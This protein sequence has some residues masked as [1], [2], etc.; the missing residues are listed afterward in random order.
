MKKTSINIAD[1]NLWGKYGAVILL[2]GG[3]KD[4]DRITLF[5]SGLQ[6]ITYVIQM[7]CIPGMLELRSLMYAMQDVVIVRYIRIMRIR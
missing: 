3:I 2:G 5:E 1:C 7:C 4:T 6:T